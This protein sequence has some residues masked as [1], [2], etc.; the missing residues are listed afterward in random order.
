MTQECKR[1]SWDEYFIQLTRITATR[2]SCKRRHIGSVIVKDHRIISTGYN[3]SPSGMKHCL[4]LGCLRDERKIES[5]TR[6]EICRGLHA[7]QNALLFARGA[8]LSDA[9]LY[10]TNHPCVV[11]AKMIIQ[12]GIRSVVYENEYPDDLAKQFFKQSG[13][14]IYKFENGER[15]LIL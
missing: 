4:D 6:A 5:G 7:E 10:C 9:T 2:S 12:S 15:S 8:D 14:K 11:C 13:V 1:P 3:G